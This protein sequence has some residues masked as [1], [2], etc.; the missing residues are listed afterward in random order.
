MAKALCFACGEIKGE[1]GLS[2]CPACGA[3]PTGDLNLDL[4][5]SDQYVTPATLA[6]FGD[7]VRSINRVT[8]EPRLR[9][10]SFA[11]F[12]SL[13]HEDLLGIEMPPAQAAECDA[14]LAQANPPAVVVEE[15]GAQ[16]LLRPEGEGND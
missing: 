4:A 9:F 3:A 15:V 5:F 12:V 1:G 11:R 8:D 7:V 6:A 13:H 14:V 2:V 10:W 16:G